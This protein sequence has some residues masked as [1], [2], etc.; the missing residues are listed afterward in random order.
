MEVSLNE[1][2]IEVVIGEEKK[3][4]GC[5]LVGWFL[6]SSRVIAVE[7]WFVMVGKAGERTG[8]CQRVL[9]YSLAKDA[10]P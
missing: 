5:G 3:F 1:C 8:D 4:V 6:Y 10:E 9:K 7:L 2:M